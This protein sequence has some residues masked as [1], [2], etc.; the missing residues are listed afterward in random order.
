MD[1]ST[2]NGEITHISDTALMVA[3]SRALESQQPDAFTSDPFAAKL[4]GDRGFAILKAIPHYGVLHFGLIIRTRFIDDLLQQLFAA[5]PIRTVLSVG[6]GLDARPWRLELPPDLRWIEVDFPAV[7]DYK[8]RVLE[9]DAPRCRLE[10]LSVDLNDPAQ[11]LKLYE[12]AGTEPALMITEGLL[13]YLPAATV[14]AVAVETAATPG[15]KHWIADIS[16]SAFTNAIGGGQTMD[17]IRRVQANDALPG[18][19]IFDTL[20]RNGWRTEFWRSYIRDLGFA[21]DRIRSMFG[22]GPK[23]SFEH[24]ATDPTGVH[25]FARK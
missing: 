16:T 3:A 11:R 15:I 20:H 8:R 6:C 4:A 17:P 5:H 24:L 10:R 12:A 22:D 9:N 18:E 25:C 19:Q 2:A 14:E 23:P 7:L 1:T 21:A 13:F